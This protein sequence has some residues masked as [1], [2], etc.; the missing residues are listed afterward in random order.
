MNLQI[1]R[2]LIIFFIVIFSGIAGQISA[3]QTAPTFTVKT[4]TGI[5]QLEDFRGRVVYVDFWA[6]WCAP[7]RKSF[8]WL[9][10]MQQKYA[11]KGLTIIGVNV[12]KK[13]SLADS[14][15]KN[16]PAEF[17][18]V[19][20][21]DGELASKYK[22]VGMPSA[23]LIDKQGVIQHNHV[24]FRPSKKMAYEASIQKLL[25]N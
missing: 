25:D 17:P 21:P 20:D 11:D 7:C 2:F 13:R 9:N 5:F 22:L 10:E 3:S 8:P 16:N 1:R 24:G 23:Y 4:G 18:I 19:Y 12:D 6:S 15:L 14:F